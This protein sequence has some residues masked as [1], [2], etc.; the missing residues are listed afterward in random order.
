MPPSE[1]SRIA[2]AECASTQFSPE[3]NLSSLQL[4]QQDSLPTT[5]EDVKDKDPQVLFDDTSEAFDSQFAADEL[6]ESFD[7]PSAP[8]GAHEQQ[9][10]PE[11]ALDLTG[12]VSTECASDTSAEIEPE[13]EPDLPS[14]SLPDIDGQQSFPSSTET[15]QESLHSH[16]EP[17]SC[18]SPKN[19]PASSSGEPCHFST[20]TSPFGPDPNCARCHTISAENDRLHRLVARLRFRLYEAL[21]T[22]QTHGQRLLRAACQDRIREITNEHA[23]QTTEI[24]N[25]QKACFEEELEAMEKESHAAINDLQVQV[26]HE[27]FEKEHMKRVFQRE[28]DAALEKTNSIMQAVQRKIAH[29]HAKATRLEREKAT[30]SAAHNEKQVMVEVLAS[31][32][33]ARDADRQKRELLSK[34][35]EEERSRKNALIDSMQGEI[36]QLRA[37]LEEEAQRSK[38]L[39]DKIEAMH[40][41]RD[42]EKERHAQDIVDCKTQ[43]QKEEDR[44]GRLFA[45]VLQ[46]Y[47]NVQSDVSTND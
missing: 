21:E 40:L 47:A 34:A 16:E 2:Q 23:Q 12:Q 1:T 5:C 46:D 28:R 39:L 41:E 27:R 9:D 44:L 29:L 20:S 36:K 25:R 15:P 45:S 8:P 11:P 6:E 26:Q 31:A 4:T 18:I 32:A 7:S 14:V 30:L 24:L 33:A 35:E 42:D 17:H 37:R 43:S 10:S 13:A 22:A 3:S 19:S 38:S